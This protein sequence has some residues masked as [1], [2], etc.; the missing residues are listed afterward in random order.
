MMTFICILLLL[1]GIGLVGYG[2]WY[3]YQWNTG[4]GATILG[5]GLLM[6]LLAVPMTVY[7]INTEIKVDTLVETGKYEIVT[8]E[9]YS[10]K[11]LEQFMNV[12]GVYLKEVEE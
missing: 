3:A 5:L 10:L 11:E 2:A 4:S 6:L 1:L 12:G 7:Y 9:D 8:N